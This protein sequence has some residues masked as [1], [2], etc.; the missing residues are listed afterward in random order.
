MKYAK[1][2]GRYQNKWR[3][4]MDETLKSL[5][6]ESKRDLNDF[7]RESENPAQEVRI[8]IQETLYFL[9]GKLVN[10]EDISQEQKESRLRFIFRCLRKQDYSKKERLTNL[11]KEVLNTKALK[12]LKSRV[13]NRLRDEEASQEGRFEIYI[14]SQAPRATIFRRLKQIMQEDGRN[15]F[16]YFGLLVTIRNDELAYLIKPDQLI[17]CLSNCI[18]FFSLTDDGERSYRVFPKADASAYFH[19]GVA[20]SLPPLKLLTKLPL[21]NQGFNI[22][23]VGY[24]HDSN[25]FRVETNLPI[26][27]GL[28]YIPSLLSEF[29]WHDPVADKTNYLA[30]LITTLLDHLFPG[31]TPFVDIEGNQKGVGKTLAANIIG[32]LR[33]AEMPRSINLTNNE[34]ELEKQL[35]SSFMNGST[36]INFDNVKLSKNM[37]TVSNPLLEKCITDKVLKFRIL[38]GNNEFKMLN[39]AL[40]IL[41]SNGAVLSPD[42]I[43][44]RLLISLYYEGNPE[45]RNF[46]IQNIEDFCVENRDHILSELVYMIEVWK[47]QKKPLSKVRHRFQKWASIVG[48]ILEANGFEG[49]L[50]ASGLEET[51]KD[52]DELDFDE[53]VMHLDPSEHYTTKQIL[54]LAKHL[55]LFKELFELPSPKA[56]QTSF[57]RTLSRF[58]GKVLPRTNLGQHKFTKLEKKSR[59]NSSL[60]GLIPQ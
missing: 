8:L 47:S 38:G 34:E 12:R 11:M 9:D 32:I 28:K 43:S 16:N 3:E 41:T 5:I 29:S 60:Y 52:S 2:K 18:E 25:M 40:F 50:E 46:K 54:D 14:G 33:D 19:S 49:F 6:N 36:T 26:A 15:Y 42:L 35:C 55:G 39:R 51:T 44:R 45:N 31:D 13:V 57:G 48:G 4:K 27:T 58:N 10:F 59:K 7:I 1:R 21:Y 20:D 24:N 30:I 17:G 37:H 53:L 23:D 22:L 56:Q